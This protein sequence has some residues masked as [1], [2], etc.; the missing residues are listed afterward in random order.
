MDLKK[1]DIVK[2]RKHMDTVR[3]NKLGTMPGKADN[4]AHGD[5]GEAEMAKT[6]PPK[7]GKAY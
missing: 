2:S 1:M 7:C 5:C 3:D 4:C 6:M